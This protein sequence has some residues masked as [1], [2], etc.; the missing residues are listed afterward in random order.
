MSRYIPS[1]RALNPRK[2]KNY[3]RQR[4][5]AETSRL[6]DENLEIIVDSY[7][8]EL[9][10]DR[11]VAKYQL[12]EKGRKGNRR[13]ETD[14]LTEAANSEGKAIEICRNVCIR[15]HGDFLLH[16]HHHLVLGSG[17]SEVNE[18]LE[19]AVFHRG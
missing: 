2:E 3:D 14:K 6:N 10:S 8:C 11:F 7:I 18:R 17:E 4:S 19:A 13:R 9:D 1:E 5:D 15:V 16:H 12:E